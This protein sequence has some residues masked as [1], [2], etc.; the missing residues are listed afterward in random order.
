MLHLRKLKV[1][2]LLFLLLLTVHCNK[3]A[4]D[5]VGPSTSIDISGKWRGTWN[6]SKIGR[7][8]NI[9]LELTQNGTDF[10]GSIEARRAECLEKGTISGSLNGDT[11]TFHLFTEKQEHIIFNGK[12]VDDIPDVNFDTPAL[13]PKKDANMNGYYSVDGGI[14]GAQGEFC[15]GDM[16]HWKIDKEDFWDVII[17]GG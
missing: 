3:D 17:P 12:V 13:P 16:G 11:I 1:M 7:D 6:S 5:P 9:S 2:I 8:G 10:N 14:Y 15:S 4:Q